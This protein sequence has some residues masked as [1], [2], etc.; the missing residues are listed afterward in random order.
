MNRAN[1]DMDESRLLDRA[2]KGDFDAFEE[3]VS[4]TE[5]KI[6]NHLLR[7]VGNPED[8]KELLQETYL[9]AYRNLGRFKEDAA[10]STWAYRIA[11]NHALMRLRRKNPETVGLDEIPVPS[12]E[13]LKRRTISDWAVDPKEAVL[14]KETRLL[15][16]RAI[17]ELPPI[18]RAVVVLRDVED[19]S[20]AETARILGVSEGAVKTRLHR[21]RLY[22]REALSPYFESGERPGATG[23]A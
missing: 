18:Y 5:G 13:E 20:T 9:S 2:R 21:A 8:A 6:Y 19:M 3:L 17:A 11:T 22:L 7:L 16:D 23:P 1:D 15:L 12:H 14:R 10:F 4:R